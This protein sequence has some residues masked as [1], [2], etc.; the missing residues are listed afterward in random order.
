MPID[1]KGKKI[2]VTGGAGFL[3][4]FVVERLLE[5]GVKRENLRIP[6]SRIC[7]LR[8]WENCVKAVDGINIV[9]H[10]AARV[11]GIGFNMRHPAEIFYDNAI[12]GIQLIETARQAGV[13]KFVVVGTVCGYPKLNPVP[14]KEECFWDGYPE[15]TNAPYGLAKKMLLPQCQSYRKQ[16]GLNSIYL[17]P[18]NLYG[19]KDHFDPEDAHV[20]PALITK[21]FNAKRREERRVMVWGTGIASRE[22]LYIEDAAEGIVLATERYEGEEPINIGSGK[23]IGIRDLVY[24]IKDMVGYER[25]VV[26]DPSKP[27]GQPKRRLDISKAKM[28]FGFEARTPFEVGLSKTI[29]WYRENKFNEKYS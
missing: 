22:F 14:F 29:D 15:E 23:E 9:I 4:S 16:Y 3:G 8:I 13:E 7:D 20:I 18:V 19:P 1:L 6:R 10:L 27:D 2:L 26:W 25:D 28:E 11:G 21:F 12:M 17:I 24:M 5:K